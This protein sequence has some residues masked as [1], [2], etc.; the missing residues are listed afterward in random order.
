MQTF[1][2]SELFFVSGM[3][4]M[5][6]GLMAVLFW[7][8]GGRLGKLASILMATLCLECVKDFFILRN[9]DTALFYTNSINTSIDTIVVPM[10]IF[11]LIELIKPG[12]LTIKSM[13]ISEIPFAALIS[14]FIA[15]RLDIFYT[16]LIILSAVSGTF[17][18]IWSAFAI[19]K[20]HKQLKEEFSYTENIN[21]NWLRVIIYTFYCILALWTI[22]SFFENP[23]YDAIYISCSLVMWIVL[24]YF[25]YKHKS[26]LNELNTDAYTVIPEQPVSA[27]KNS[28]LKDKIENLFTKDKIFLNPQL[29]ITDIA[30][31]V[32]TNRT[33]VSQFFNQQNSSTFFDYVNS[34]RIE[35]ACKLLSGTNENITV[36]SEKSGFSNIQSFYRVF[37]RIKGMTP[38]AYRNSLN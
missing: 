5:F 4:T 14:M 38:A 29:K 17:F 10:Y 11:I 8:K 36:I 30:D 7:I 26:V 22:S 13:L 2:Y 20:Y 15:T 33:Y 12:R 24:D 19:P 34:F 9:P 21:L 18:L 1:E 28:E 35:Y 25:I 32:G 37:S 6:Y 23:D 31:K 27:E 3:S 16:L